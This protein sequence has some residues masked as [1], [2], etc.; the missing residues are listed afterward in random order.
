MRTWLHRIATNERRMLRRR[1]VPVSLDELLEE[2]A[3][4]P[5]EPFQVPAGWLDPEDAAVEAETR[6]QVVAALAGLPDRY[7]TAVVLKDGFWLPLKAWPRP[8]A[9]PC[10]RSGRCCT[11]WATLRESLSAPQSR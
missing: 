4:A 9:S 6:R 3:T 7:R 5:A 8:W 11:G 1:K 2:A 10:R